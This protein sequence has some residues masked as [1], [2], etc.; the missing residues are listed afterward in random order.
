MKKYLASAAAATAFTAVAVLAPISSASADEPGGSAGLVNI[1]LLAEA[2]VTATIQEV[3]DAFV[4]LS[5]NL[6]AFA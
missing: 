1:D 2:G 3:A 6:F 4:D 5:L